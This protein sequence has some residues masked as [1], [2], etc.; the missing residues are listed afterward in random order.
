M[1]PW[2]LLQDQS[3]N[4]PGDNLASG[5]QTTIFVLTK[6]L[7]INTHDEDHRALFQ[8]LIIIHK[9]GYY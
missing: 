9:N 6:V 2:Y 5:Y 8:N 4:T 3:I 1:Q 7:K